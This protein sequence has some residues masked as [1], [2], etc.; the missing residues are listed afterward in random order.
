MI[1]GKVPDE[2]WRSRKPWL[3]IPDLLWDIISFFVIFFSIADVVE[4][5][6]FPGLLAPRPE[7][8]Q[9]HW[10]RTCV[11]SFRLSVPSSHPGPQRISQVVQ[12]LIWVWADASS[13]APLESALTPPALIKELNDKEL[14]DA[15]RVVPLTVAHRDMAYG[16]DFLMENVLV[17]S[18]ALP[19]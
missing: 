10:R 3:Q 4:A 15:G 14:N 11:L 7:R 16:W 6:M 17:S 1:C 8:Q 18:R 19:S 12:D 13:D 9:Q 5:R 2:N